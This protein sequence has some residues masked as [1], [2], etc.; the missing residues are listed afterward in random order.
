MIKDATALTKIRKD[1]T[2]VE[3][4]RVSLD[5][6]AYATLPGLFPFTL[7]NAAHNLPFLHA[8]AILNEALEQLKEEGLF[9]CG[10]RKLGH[11]LK[12]SKKVLPWRDFAL[13]KAGV[14]HRND[15][16]HKGKLLNRPECWTYIDAIKAELSAWGIL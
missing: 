13:I 1:W 6:S 12:A 2:G 4:L 8:F 3:A 14:V 16:A 11:L 9:K 10:S 5:V 7:Y 15:L